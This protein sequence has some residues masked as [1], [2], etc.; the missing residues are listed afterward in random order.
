MYTDIDRCIYI[1]IVCNA[2]YDERHAL[3]V[4]YMYIYTHI[5]IYIYEYT[6]LYRYVDICVYI[7]SSN[8]PYI[9]SNEICILFKGP[10]NLSTEPYILSKELYILSKYSLSKEP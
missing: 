5:Y 10:Y 8:N 3:Y 6:A 7:D 9:L 2:C 4:L 1:Y